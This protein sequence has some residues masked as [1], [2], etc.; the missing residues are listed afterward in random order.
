[1]N[2]FITGS[3]I[4]G[5]PT[6]DSDV[7]LVVLMEPDAGFDLATLFGAEIERG[8]NNYPGAQFLAGS[9]NII[10]CTDTDEFDI[11]QRGTCE[12]E[13]RKPVTRDEA[14]AHFAKLRAEAAASH[15]AVEDARIKANDFTE[16]GV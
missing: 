6:P 16:D 15:K 11:W 4:Y 13:A 14:K 10:L 7:D 9:L 3:Q 5:T 2:A 1:M 8:K 12:L